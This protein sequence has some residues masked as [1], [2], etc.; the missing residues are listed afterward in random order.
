[1]MIRTTILLFWAAFHSNHPQILFWSKTSHGHQRIPRI[2]MCV[3]CCL[4]C[5][6]FCCR[7]CFFWH[8]PSDPCLSHSSHVLAIVSDR[9]LFCIRE[10][11]SQ[12]VPMLIRMR[13]MCIT[14]LQELLV[15]LRFLPPEIQFTRVIASSFSQ[16]FSGCLLQCPHSAPQLRAA[17]WAHL[18]A[19]SLPANILPSALALWIEG[20]L[21]VRRGLGCCSSGCPSVD[22]HSAFLF[23]FCMGFCNVCVWCFCWQC[24]C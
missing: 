4:S 14:K 16:P 6:C 18:R 21:R 24:C 11:R 17:C 20:K 7:L 8:L 22:V 1:M 13:D 15:Y 9:S 10:L 5:R 19:L 23:E 12:H 2:C 3:L